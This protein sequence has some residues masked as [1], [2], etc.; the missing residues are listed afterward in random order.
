VASKASTN[1][2]TNFATFGELLKHL[3][4]RAGL[5]Q[6][7][8]ALAVGY[9]EA[10]INRLEKNHRLPDPSVIA[11]HFVAALQLKNE[12]ELAARLLELA[13][14]AHQPA[15]RLHNFA[16]QPTPFIGRETE[17]V[18]IA[19]HLRDPDCRLLTLFGPPGIG[20][21]RLALQAAAQAARAFADGACL[22]SLAPVNAAEFMVSAIAEALRIPFYGPIDPKAQLL[23]HLR[24]KNMLLVLDNFEHL[25]VASQDS[26]GSGLLV[27]LLTAA[28][29][30][31]LLVTSRERL[32]LQWEWVFEVGGLAVPES[33]QAE[34]IDGYSAVQLFIQSARR[35]QSHF[36]LIEAVQPYVARI[37]RVLEGMP[38]GI[39]LAASWTYAYSSRRIASEIEHNLG[40]LTAA[41]RD[42]P[43]RHRS[44]RAT[45]DHS[46]DLLTDDERAAF[47]RLSV[48]QGGFRREAAE[49]VA[50]ASPE[51]L[52]ALVDK[53]LLRRNPAGRYDLH[54]RL[55]QYGEEK[56]R[57]A[58]DEDGQ[59]HD[60]HCDYYT[61][62]VQR[63]ENDFKGGRQKEAVEEVS[64]EIDNVRAG[65]EWATSHTRIENIGNFIEGLWFFY[66]LHSWLQEGDD[67]FA[68]AVTCLT[69]ANSIEA[70]RD[71]RSAVLLANALLW[72]GLLRAYRGRYPEARP[73]FSESLAR[74][75]RLG[76]GR[77]MTLPLQNLSYYEYQA[78]EYEA[79]R[80]HAQESVELSQVYNDPMA[81]S[82]ASAVLGLICYVQGNY[83]DAKRMLLNSLSI[84]RQ[85]GDQRGLAAQL[86]FLG[87]ILLASEGYEAA[88][89]F[90]S[91]G[92][93]VGR[94][95]G[96]RLMAAYCLAHWGAALSEAGEYQEAKHK[97]EEGLAIYRET[98]DATGIVRAYDGLGHAAWGMDDNAE[99]RQHFLN[100]VKVGMRLGAVP[101]VLAAFLGF[102]VL[103][104]Q[105]DKHAQAAELCVLAQ[106][107]S[108]STWQTKDRAE[109]L[110]ME[111]KKE[112]PA[113]VWAAAQARSRTRSLEEVAAE[114]LAS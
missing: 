7:D 52:A 64:G 17:L 31:K 55:R 74:L 20:K 91:E 65:W 62:F 4:R 50:G 73:M 69:A 49:V 58:P 22:V 43:A 77:R 56:L 38:L 40:F 9:S 82:N 36:T 87:D 72:Q 88:Q 8:L 109:R 21:T 34:A 105:E 83:A 10:H 101:E 29:G 114:V 14:A 27:D 15:A 111:L 46:W 24:E 60:R 3:R 16:P 110:L 99:A 53:A 45:F 68:M 2:L 85:V 75:H 11:T 106:Q 76:V 57:A 30:V 54:E 86:T 98:G 78:G 13:A 25:L 63:H 51:V 59:T 48:F 33:E 28:P 84:I 104:K 19:Q 26:H 92:L 100:A 103:L 70:D 96:D 23:N 6:R 67:A 112:L 32:R 41:V 71:V 44:L 94:A 18:E 97:L 37:C 61:E 95:A 35:A 39:E 102:A 93:S 5:T 66:V 108:A 81:L 113:E 90:F 1:L 42:M 79:A 80:Q 89:P 47:R 107:H 12:P